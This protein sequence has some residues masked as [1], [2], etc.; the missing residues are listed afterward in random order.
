MFLKKVRYENRI[1]T[2]KGNYLSFMGNIVLIDFK[3]IIVDSSSRST[4]IE[5]FK[6]YYH[7]RMEKSKQ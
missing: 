1:Y 6:F 2:E 5:K 7:N 4:F 3:R